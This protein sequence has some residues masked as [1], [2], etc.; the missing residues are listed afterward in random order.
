MSYLITRRHIV[1]GM[2]SKRYVAANARCFIEGS[3]P[4]PDRAL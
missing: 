3:N 1:G 4:A 2:A